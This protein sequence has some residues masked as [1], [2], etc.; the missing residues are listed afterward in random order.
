[1][2]N[3]KNSHQSFIRP[4]KLSQKTLKPLKNSKNTKK[5]L[6]KPVKNLPDCARWLLDSATRLLNS[7]RWLLDSNKRHPD[8]SSWQLYYA[9]WLLASKKWLYTLPVERLK[10]VNENIQIKIP[11][12]DCYFTL[13]DLITKH[14]L[15]TSKTPHYYLLILSKNPRMLW[16]TLKKFVKH[17]QTTW[18]PG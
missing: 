2:K 15:E 12:N 1:V 9:T 5:N 17:L 16:K 3:H 18:K 8:Y 4:S 11:K 6:Q 10:R 13:D 7:S 14:S